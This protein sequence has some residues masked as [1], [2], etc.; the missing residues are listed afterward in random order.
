[1]PLSRV[2]GVVTASGAHNAAAP[3]AVDRCRATPL[4]RIAIGGRREGGWRGFRLLLAHQ[5][6]S[7]CSPSRGGRVDVIGG[8]A[9]PDDLGDVAGVLVVAHEG[10]AQPFASSLLGIGGL[11]DALGPLRGANAGHEAPPSG[12]GGIAAAASSSV[13]HSKQRSSGPQP[14][15]RGPPGSSA[16]SLMIARTAIPIAVASSSAGVQSEHRSSGPQSHGLA[17]APASSAGTV[18]HGRRVT[19]WPGALSPPIPRALY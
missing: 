12:K 3:A 1:M 13:A 4:G 18:T 14:H 8:V 19:R 15:G 6:P 5:N 10:D 17:T 9:V 2:R 11:G 7:P 16:S